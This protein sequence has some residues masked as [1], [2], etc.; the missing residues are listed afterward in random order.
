M[1]CHLVF[2]LSLSS[3]VFSQ[4]C[5]KNGVYELEVQTEKGMVKD[6]GGRARGASCR[7]LYPVHTCYHKISPF[8]PR[9]LV[10]WGGLAGTP[11]K[12]ALLHALHACLLSCRSGVSFDPC[13]GFA[14]LFDGYVL[15][16]GYEAGG[17][18][19]F[20]QL[21][22]HDTPPLLS[23]TK[24]KCIDIRSFIKKKKTLIMRFYMLSYLFFTRS[25]FF[26]LRPKYP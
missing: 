3:N 10:D 14:V 7:S 2:S 6:G 9:P 1:Y 19:F 22:L 25:C 4:T 23:R 26:I 18:A 5:S 20:L 16:V 8:L 11:T 21:I 13:A 12:E 15:S 17:R 24:L